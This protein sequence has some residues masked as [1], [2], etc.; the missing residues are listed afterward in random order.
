[1][2]N[3]KLNGAKPAESLL[4][5]MNPQDM[6]QPPQPVPGPAQPQ[7]T[8]ASQ[9]RK[10]GSKGLLI[11]LIVF[12]VAFIGSSSFAI[13]AFIGR[14][15][16]K[17]NT[18]DKVAAAVKDAVKQAEEA[19]D[20][21][22][23]EKEKSPYKTY[24]SPATY[25]AIE[26]TYPK[27]W[28]AMI[29]EA[30]GST[31]INGYF[32]P[33]YVPGPKSGQAFALRLEVIERPYDQVLS[34]YDSEAKKGS[35]K[36]SPFKAKQVPSVL[37]ARLDGEVERG[38]QGSAV[39]LPLRDKTIRLSTLSSGSFIKDFNEIVLAELNFTP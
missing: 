24:K 35:I 13:W 27:T 17:N 31:P 28:S 38:F 32:H 26:I 34:T 29:D 39:L 14:Q 2:N 22:F 10:H 8:S 7:F 11:S 3:I 18:D 37:G 4:P 9:Q 19:K 20:K 36:I 25:G 1:M 21:E 23:V 30:K 33:G 15:D 16:Y 12:I 6:Y 5:G